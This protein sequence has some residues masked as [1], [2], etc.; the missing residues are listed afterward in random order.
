MEVPFNFSEHGNI[1]PCSV[2]SKNCGKKY[3]GQQEGTR[4]KIF[5][6]YFFNQEWF[7]LSGF[8]FLEAIVELFYFI[9]THEY[10]ALR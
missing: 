3:T 8:Y 7:D 1:Y 9:N 5:C 6:L 4:R 10:P 2:R